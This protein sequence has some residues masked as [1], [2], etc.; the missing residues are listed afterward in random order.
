MF[1]SH[2]SIAGGLVGALHEATGLG[3]DTVQVFTKNQRQW[4]VAPLDP[5]AALEW[6]SELARLKWQGRAVAHDSYLINLASPDDSPGGLWEKSLATMRIEISRCAALAIP[7]LVSHPGAHMIKEGPLDGA[8]R[9]EAGL[10]RIA[11]AYGRLLRESRDVPVTICLE[12]TAG[13]GTTLG[14]SFE[15]LARL[16]ELILQEAG[17]NADLNGVAGGR[18]GFCLDTCHALAAGYDISASDETGRA[19][20]LAEGRRLGKA[21]LDEFDRVC[22]LANLRV[23]HLNDSH[24]ALGSHIDRHAHIGQ[25]RVALGAFAAVVSHPGLAR[26]P[27]IMETPKEPSSGGEPMDLLNL[28]VLKA[29]EAGAEPVVEAPASPAAAAPTRSAKKGSSTPAVTKASKKKPAKT[30]AKKA[31][32]KVAKKA[33]RKAPKQATTQKPSRPA[34]ARRRSPGSSS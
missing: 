20:S 33:P 3:L 12:N 19:R 11:R 28:R 15:E 1:G 31:A 32:K 2:L 21:M 34:P 8:A 27:K 22:G 30:A 5:G 4:S 25:G 14:R 18:I 26:A 29:L 9:V 23:L 10:V 13:G 7:F 6:V 17:H 16:R 24:G